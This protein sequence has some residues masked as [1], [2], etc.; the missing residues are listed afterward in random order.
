MGGVA[1][2]EAK[3]KRSEGKAAATV[4]LA[5]AESGA[6]HTVQQALAADGVTQTDYKVSQR[7]LQMMGKA[8]NVVQKKTIYLPYAAGD[9]MGNVMGNMP[10]LFGRNAQPQNLSK[11]GLRRRGPS[12][13]V[14]ESGS[15]AEAVMG[16]GASK[17]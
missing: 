11:N 5:Q 16:G 15:S 7:Y 17:G 4:K 12:S 8:I 10:K 1:E 2:Q 14:G 13:T 3:R 6:L 9:L